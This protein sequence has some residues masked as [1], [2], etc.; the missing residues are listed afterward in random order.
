MDIYAKRE[1]Q[2]NYTETIHGFE[3]LIVTASREVVCRVHREKAVRDNSGLYR[4]H[5]CVPLKKC[6]RCGFE[7]GASFFPR[8]AWLAGKRYSLRSI[9]Y[10]CVR[11][12]RALAWRERHAFEA[13]VGK[14]PWVALELHDP[15]DP[16]CLYWLAMRNSVVAVD[17]DELKAT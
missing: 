15:D 9:C 13:V 1:P 11:E 16:E 4:C 17:I 2:K 12:L 7:A 6:R 14:K 5:S 3:N 10:G 8:R